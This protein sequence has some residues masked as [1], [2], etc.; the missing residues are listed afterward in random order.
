MFMN[1]VKKKKMKKT[2]K[3]KLLRNECSSNMGKKIFNTY[4]LQGKMH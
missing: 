1:K 4:E 3:K 2:T